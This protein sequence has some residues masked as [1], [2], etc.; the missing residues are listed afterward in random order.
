MALAGLNEADLC[1]P[2]QFS[3]LVSYRDVDMTSLPADL[4]EFDFSWSSSAFEHL[5]TLEAGMEF[6]CREMAFVRPGGVAVHTTE[7]NASSDDTTIDRRPIK[8]TKERG[9]PV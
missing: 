3:K 2:T 6:V 9:S 1:D 8:D 4:G 7:Y 5:G